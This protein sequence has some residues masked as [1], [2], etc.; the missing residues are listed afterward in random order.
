MNKRA[1]LSNIRINGN[2]QIRSENAIKWMMEYEKRRVSESMRKKRIR[3]EYLDRY[4]L[5]QSLKD[6]PTQAEPEPNLVAAFAEQVNHLSY[7]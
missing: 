3:L 6:R 4:G 5:R 7:S 1:S 2:P